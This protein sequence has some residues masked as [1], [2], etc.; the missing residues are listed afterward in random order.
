MESKS[1]N[2]CSAGDVETTFYN[3]QTESKPSLK[4]HKQKQ[5]KQPRLIKKKER[6]VVAW[7]L[8]ILHQ[9]ETITFTWEKVKISTSNYVY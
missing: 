9:A 2:F 3:I 6:N 4:K 7:T 1:T 8:E 5:K